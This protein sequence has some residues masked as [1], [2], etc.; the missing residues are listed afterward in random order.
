MGASSTAVLSPS[1][2]LR[3]EKCRGRGVRRP[4]TFDV[5]WLW[6]DRLVGPRIETDLAEQIAA[7]EAG[8]PYRSPDWRNSS[9]YLE[10]CEECGHRPDLKLEK[11]TRK[12]ADAVRSWELVLYI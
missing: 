5:V 9:P 4:P 2:E 8:R 6:G 11:L 7:L 1:V 10:K 12:V 3:C